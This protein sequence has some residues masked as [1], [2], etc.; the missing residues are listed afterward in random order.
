LDEEC[1]AADGETALG[2]LR[3]LVDI[4]NRAMDITI[5]EI[6]KANS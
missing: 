4:V 5:S 2:I 3:S 1:T 6:E